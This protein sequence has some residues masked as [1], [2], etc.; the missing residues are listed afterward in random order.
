MIFSF[1]IYNYLLLVVPMLIYVGLMK[2]KV[3]YPFWQICLV[4][5]YG[6]LVNF[7]LMYLRKYL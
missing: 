5:G 3:R 2:D 4:L 1:F 7:L 6:V